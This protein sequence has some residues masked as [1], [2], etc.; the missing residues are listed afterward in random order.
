MKSFTIFNHGTGGW[1]GK[2]VKSAEIVN[3]FGNEYGR[4]NQECVDYLITEGVGGKGDPHLLA[5]NHM[6]GTLSSKIGSIDRIPTLK[7]GLNSVFGHGVKQNVDNVITTLKWLDKSGRR[8]DVINMIGWS[9]GAVTC[10]RIAYALNQLSGHLSNIPINIFAVDPVAGLNKH[11]D[12]DAH[13]LTANVNN[14]IG[15]LALHEKRA[16]FTP[17]DHRI[18]KV[19]PINSN[20]I[21]LPLPGIHNDT[22]KYTNPAGRITFHLAHRFLV[23]MGSRLPNS[24]GMFSMSDRGVLGQYN[25]LRKPTKSLHKADRVKPRNNYKDILTG[26]WNFL[27]GRQKINLSD[28]TTDSDFFINPH[29]RAVFKRLFPVAYEAFFGI[30]R[31]TLRTEQWDK[32]WLPR[33]QNDQKSKQLTEIETE[34]LCKLAPRQEDI[35]SETRGEILNT[36][37]LI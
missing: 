15:T 16:G 5:L 21:V 6:G 30:G 1:S 14:Y 28:L 17:V 9:R 20:T 31:T 33:L 19:N 25:L 37:N 26:G 10:I 7:R 4:E 12:T 34:L 22:T 35:Y 8:P 32:T 2:P 11:H 23:A 13:T 3:I 36:L 18:L 27:G 24:L 29:H